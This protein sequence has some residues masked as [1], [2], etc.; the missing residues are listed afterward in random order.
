MNFPRGGLAII[1]VL[2]SAGHQACF[3]GGCVR[4]QLLGL[5]VKE[6]DITTSARPEEVTRLFAKVVPTG[7]EYGTVTILADDGQY[8]VTT[9]RADEKYVDG[10]HPANVVFTAD[11]HQ[12][13]ARRDFTIN[14]LALD[15]VN[16]RLV[17]DFKGQADLKAK[18]IR[19]IGDPVAR[20]SED[21][22]RSLRACRL[23]AV[24]E[25]TLE[26]KTLA[27]ITQTLAVT[28]KVAA[29]R[30]HDE[31]IK[32]LKARRPSIGLE[33]M[34]QTGLLH[35]ILPDLVNCY[36]M[37]QPPEFHNHDVYW[38]SLYSCDAAPPDNYPVR[39]AALLHDLGKPACQEGYTFYNHERV[40]AELAETALRRLKFSNDD[41]AKIVN[42]IL[43]HMFDYHGDWGEAAVRR[44]I[45]RIGGLANVADLFALRRAE[46]AAMIKTNDGSY[47]TELQQR[48]DKVIA[49]QNALQVTDLK[50]DGQDVMAVLQIPP[51]P[52]VGQILNDLLEKVLDDPNLNNRDSLLELIRNYA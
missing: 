23:A 44:F 17:D 33:L 29:E 35:L 51:G 5:P 16:D 19:A 45:R 12:D 20:L 14:A 7:L 10:R 2:Q 49:D 48:I 9:F 38:H 30:I 26:P 37:A 50:V 46:T 36:G 41:I 15:P 47:L 52:K 8:E 4:D 31:L 22:L 34:R 25:F 39:L 32:L 27:A 1:Q 40:G 43:N 3:V 42:L 28:K 18:I 21:G 13:L 11:L 6:W 24:L